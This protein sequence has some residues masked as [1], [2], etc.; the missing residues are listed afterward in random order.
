MG[1]I[2]VLVVDDSA[3]MR[4]VISDILNSSTEIEVVAT[5]ANGVEA[6]K[7]LER[8][9]VDVVT[10]DFQMPE[11]D[12]LTTLKHIM[13]ENPKPVVMISAFTKTGVEETI[14][15]LEAGAADFVTKP[16]GE[17]DVNLK[18]T[19]RDEIVTKIIIAS[20]ANISILRKEATKAMPE[21]PH[22]EQ[23][24]I[25]SELEPHPTEAY[26]DK[27]K[28]IIIGSSTGGPQTL[29]RVIPLLPES[30]PAPV[31]IVQ[32]MPPVFTKSLAERLDR[33][34]QLKVK[35]AEEGDIIEKGKVYIAPGDY[36]MELRRGISDGIKVDK[37]TLNQ[38][39][40]EE[41]V[42]PSINFTLRSASESYKDKVVGVILT[43]MGSD[44]TDGM[45]AVK[46]QKGVCIAQNKD[47]SIIY[48]MPKA[49][50]DAGLADYVLPLDQIPAKIVECASN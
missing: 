48:G 31:L 8:N 6:L 32:H 40:R 5:A 26:A 35:E 46:A 12:G 14:K 28:I 7:K 38:N 30:L 19:S 29:E 39:P 25:V 15:S 41:G 22:V 9:E 17:V 23:Q 42:R 34:S 11:M 37:I 2:K 45:R 4:K 20:R 24:T 10:L 47:T 27:G 43:G 16:E 50:A 21:I 44:G 13:A 3:L 1:K 18:N 33:L 36:H 49:V